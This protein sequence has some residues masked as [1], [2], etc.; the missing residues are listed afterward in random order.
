MALVV[1]R[2]NED[3]EWV[4]DFPT[5]YLYNKGN[6]DT[7]SDVLKHY[8]INLPNVGRES[9]T[10]L[11][12]IIHN[13]DVLDDITIFTQGTYSDHCEMSVDKFRDVFSNIDAYS[14]NYMDSTCWGGYRRYYN[15]KI[16]YW[17]AEV[18]NE[19]K[20][21]GPWFESVFNQPFNDSTIV[22]RGGIFS[23]SK[24]TIL[25]RPKSFYEML[26]KEVEYDNNPIEGHF[27]ERSWL[28]VFCIDSKLG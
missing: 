11:Y 17:T 23:V 22:Y 24:S 19:D 21:Y 27:M 13:Y 3:I 10:Y 8:T 28:E 18:K 9:H 20:E 4:K 5:K 12:H 7:I 1:A 6:I 2:Y 15:F 25:K 14:K 16:K 26:L